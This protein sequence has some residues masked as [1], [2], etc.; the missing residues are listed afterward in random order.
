MKNS[1]S[2]VFVGA[3]L[4]LSLIACGSRTDS[5]YNSDTYFSSN[6]RLFDPNNLEKKPTAPDAALVNFIGNQKIKKSD[7]MRSL[8]ALHTSFQTSYIGYSLK[9]DLIGTSSSRIFDNCEKEISQGPKEYSSIE[10]YDLVTRCL[11]KFQDT[12]L[13]LSQ[14]NR[15]PSVLTA[16]AEAVLIEDKLYIAQIR[17]NL[18]KRLEQ[19]AKVAE[20]DFAKK[21]KTGFE[22]VTIDGDSPLNAINLLMPY[23]GASTPAARKTDAVENLFARY[24][25]HP[26]KSEVTLEIK[27]SEGQIEEVILPWLQYT[28]KKNTQGS[29]ESR[30][31][32]E[33]QGLMRSTVLSD[34]EKLTVRK[35][36]TFDNVLYSDLTNKKSYVDDDGDDVLIIGIAKIEDRRACYVK[37]NTF[38]IDKDSTGQRMVYEEIGTHKNK[39]NFF[40]ILKNF[41]GN[42]EVFST[43]LV[44]DLRF[45]GGGATNVADE[46]ITL[47]TKTDAPKV[48]S[49]H[50]QLLTAGNLGM[51]SGL[52]NDIDSAEPNV[53]TK[54]NFSAAQSAASK[55]QKITDWSVFRSLKN[56]L[57]VYSQK[58]VALISPKCI[59]ACE[60]LTNH[61]KVSARAVVLGTP[62]S[63]T[64]F[65]FNTSGK[66][67]TKFRDPLNLLEISVPNFA[68]QSVQIAHEVGFEKDENTMAAAV[69]YNEI[70]IMENTP[71]LPDTVVNYKLEDLTQN[72]SE[73][74]KAVAQALK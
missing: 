1:V 61:L 12:H 31:L 64:G 16:V 25:M 4:T 58:I 44:F 19:I 21:L 11:A 35:G 14:M 63:G 37:L 23:V 57:G 20:G 69:P 59:S 45:N 51:I 53:A 54:I 30:T 13:N 60:I 33:L 48:Y 66:G 18:I 49:A 50:A 55:K 9:K 26:K 36:N 42:C 34:D 2:F 74:K 27:N 47:L 65:G 3:F 5:P 67:T 29:P 8:K 7:V 68:F 15:P 56:D 39:R 70:K 22:I 41:L 17:P 32:L 71:M 38:S 73:Y 43:P 62:T 10:Y 40:E 46:I 72:F 6:I 28:D 52:L 24:N